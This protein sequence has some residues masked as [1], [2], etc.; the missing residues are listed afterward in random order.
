MKLPPLSLEA[1]RAGT[2]AIE[3]CDA[4]ASTRH[5]THFY[6]PLIQPTPTEGF[7]CYWSFAAERQ[8]V[9]LNRLAGVEGPLTTDNVIA[10]NRFTNAFRASDRVSQYLITKVQYDREWE[11]LD[12]FVRT[13]IFKIF[14]RIDTWCYLLEVIGEPDCDSL[15]DHS[16]ERALDQVA[17]ERPLYSAAYIV[18]PPRSLT[19]PKYKRHL[20]LLRRMLDDNAHLEIQSASTMAEA[21]RTLRRY[22]SIGP[23]LAYQFVTDLNYSVHLSFSEEEFVAAGP[24]AVRGLRKCFSDAGDFSEEDLL[25]WTADRQDSEFAKRGLPWEGLWGR[26]LQLVDVQNLYCE[27]DKY[28][29]VALPHLT[30]Y[31]PGKRIKQRYRPTPAPMTAWFPPKWGI[32]DL[33]SSWTVFPTRAMPLKVM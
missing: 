6:S 29:R 22:D 13:L 16:V 7:A 1:L 32:N 17:G 11:W 27:V 31:A 19:G 23:F 18:P 12:T 20:A 21:F 4:T 26:Q 9:Y 30:Q 5:V 10:A 8:Q 24:G 2:F 33:V 25:R 28:T 3:P 15:R 14:N